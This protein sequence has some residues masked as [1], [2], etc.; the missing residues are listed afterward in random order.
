MLAQIDN[1]GKERV[2]SYASRSLTPREENYSTME[3]EA[4]AI[5]FAT[6]HFRVYLVGHKFQIITN[7][8]ALKWLH[9]IEPKGRIA[10]WIM[11][12]QEFNFTVAHR[13]G[14]S[15]ANADAL[16]RLH[17][18]SLPDQTSYAPRTVSC[19]VNLLPDT[20][21]YDAQRLDPHV[22]KVIELKEHSFPKP[23]IFVWK[24]DPIFYTFWHFW[25]E[26]HVVNGILVR[27]QISQQGFHENQL[28]YQQSLLL[29]Y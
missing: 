29:R 22:S 20:N 17:H 27:S 5:A 13:P 6:Q 14:V 26:L 7:H 3:K 21:L 25:D 23:P 2:V 18:Q 9:S 8:R 19:L 16:S 24:K 1:K 15:N 12:L 11:D 10:R 4:L 28:L